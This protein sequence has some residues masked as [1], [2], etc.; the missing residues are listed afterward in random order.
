MEGEIFQYLLRCLLDFIPCGSTTFIKHI[1]IC[2]FSAVNGTRFVR[3][4]PIF[5]KTSKNDLYEFSICSG[6][7]R[8]LEKRT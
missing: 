2:K 3:Y 6:R 4:D 1:K 5:F 8:N 7:E